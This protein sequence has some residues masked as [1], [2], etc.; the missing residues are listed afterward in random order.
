[1]RLCELKPEFLKM[2]QAI[3]IKVKSLFSNNQDNT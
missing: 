3:N 1:M 2:E